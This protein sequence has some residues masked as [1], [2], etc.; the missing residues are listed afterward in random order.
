MV[1]V[2]MSL[3]LT[4]RTRSRVLTKFHQ[5]KRSRIQY[6][7]LKC[8]KNHPDTELVI[9]PYNATHQFPEHERRGHLVYCRDRR[10]LALCRLICKMAKML[11]KSQTPSLGPLARLL[12]TYDRIVE[13]QKYAEP[14]PGRHGYLRNPPFY[15]STE[16]EAI[17]Y[18]VP[19]PPSPPAK[20]RTPA[21]VRW[22]DRHEA[23]RDSLDRRSSFS[24]D[25]YVGKPTLPPPM[26]GTYDPR[27]REMSQGVGPRY[28]SD[29]EISF[30]APGATS[31]VIDGAPPNLRRPNP[32]GSDVIPPPPP[33][34]RNTSP[35]LRA[36]R[37]V[38]SSAAATRR[39]SPAVARGAVGP[40]VT[41]RRPSP[42]NPR[43]EAPKLG[44]PRRPRPSDQ[45][46][47]DTEAEMEKISFEREIQTRFPKSSKFRSRARPPPLPLSGVASS[48]EGCASPL[49]G[50]ASSD[51]GSQLD[52]EGLPVELTLE[53]G[54][55][56]PRRKSSSSPAIPKQRG[57]DTS[58]FSY[59]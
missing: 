5:I 38:L 57:S 40:P 25:S 13:M 49:E 56:V 39:I 12:P 9:C 11:V 21:R 36:R 26:A 34:S 59:T 58:Y 45:S 53:M 37:V 27:L 52:E 42:S 22:S 17:D 46:S 2:V 33:P 10:I 28:S 54:R 31:S 48:T 29:S 47:T 32:M 55:L 50:R 3:P 43:V 24:E 35:S 20:P 8:S 18:Q 6:H 44:P 19:R 23:L 7:I 1:R 14:L 15:G 16:L 41:G 4:W 51:F 30:G